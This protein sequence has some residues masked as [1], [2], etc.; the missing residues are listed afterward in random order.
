MTV[1]LPNEAPGLAEGLAEAPQLLCLLH[2]REDDAVGVGQAISGAGWIES[3]VHI[4]SVGVFLAGHYLGHASLGVQPAIFT[5]LTG[6]QPPPDAGVFLFSVIVPPMA[7]SMAVLEL[8]LVTADGPH[9]HQIRLQVAPDRAAATRARPRLHLISAQPEAPAALAPS[10]FLTCEE[11]DIADDGQFAVKGWAFCPDGETCVRVL[12]DDCEVAQIVPDGARPDVVRAHPGQPAAS[13]AGFRVTGHAAGP[14]AST[15]RLRLL[16]RGPDGQDYSAS[17]TLPVRPTSV[18]ALTFARAARPAIQCFLDLPKCS[19]NTALGVTRGD[20]VINGWAFSPHGVTEIAVLV[21]G[22]AVGNARRGIRRDDVQRAFPTDDPGRPGFSFIVPA[23]ALKA[24]NHAITI[25]IR[26][27]Q[28]NRETIAFQARTEPDRRATPPWPLRQ[29]LPKAEI[30]LAYALLAARDAQPC[31]AVIVPAEATDHAK[32]AATLASLRRQAY[33]NWRCVV[34]LPSG[35]DAAKLLRRLSDDLRG[36]AI[37]CIADGAALGALVPEADGLMVLAPGDRLAAD[38]LLEFAVAASG[39]AADFLYGDDRRLDPGDGRHK[40]FHKP[41][42]SPNLLI[43]T[44][45]IGRAWLARR[46]LVAG[47]GLTMGDMRDHGTWDAVLR[48]T[49]HAQQE[50]AG[51]AHF[52]HMLLDSQLT[53]VDAGQDRQAL[54]RAL[55]RRGRFGSIRRGPIAG[56]Y[57]V[58]AAQMPQP[59]RVS[60]II[61]TI[62]AGDLVRTAITSIRAYTAWPDYEIICIDNMPA[63]DDPEIV[64]RKAWLT[65]YADRVI[66]APPPFNWSRLNNLGAAAAT[67]ALLLFLNDDI[68]V[69]DTAWLGDLVAQASRP[70]I[71]LVGPQLLYPDGRVQH[72]GMFLAD[73][74]A[75][76][77]FRY[78]PAD[79]PGPFGLARTTREVSAITG[80]CMMMRRDVFDRLDGF[81]EAHA[82][83]NNDIDFCLRAQ[84][85][86]L[87]VLYAPDVSLVHHELAS[88]GALPDIYNIAQFAAA[89]GGRFALGDP[90]HPPALARDSDDYASDPEPVRWST[91]GRP[92]FDR[93]AVQRIL[94][95]KLDHIGDFI[96]A[97]PAFRRIK[98]HFPDAELVVLAAPGSQPLAALEPAIDRI[99]GF[100]FFHPRS[101]RGRRTHSRAVLDALGARLAAERFDLAIDLRRQSDTR[102]MLQASEATWFAGFDHDNAHPWL[103]ISVAFE[104]DE[105]R[106]FKRGHVSDSLVRLVDAVASESEDRRDL[107]L[108]GSDRVSA[109]ATLHALRLRTGMVPPE[110]SGPLVAIHAC[111]GSANKQWPLASFAALIDLLRGDGATILLVGAP[112][113]VPSIRRLKAL[114]RQPDQIIDLVGQTSMA[115]LA[116]LLPAV[117]LFVGNDSGPKHLAAGL[118][119]PTL[120]IHSGTVDAGEWGAV[121]AYALTIRKEVACSPCYLRRV[122]DCP[123]GMVCLTG[124]A[125]GDVYR[126]TQRLIGLVAS[127]HD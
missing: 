94:A 5:A 45:Y 63:D 108:T 119:V 90:L 122:A 106:Q 61:P 105:A 101:G 24:G 60:I 64:A 116:A 124:I 66:V 118:G 47:A 99:I 31:W 29:A 79:A 100:D 93:R 54:G 91:A 115:E 120:G 78:A 57:R 1:E 121:G 14:F 80:A 9:I 27:R 56:T 38:A 62:A 55:R 102:H 127:N 16:L 111:A 113:D 97:F 7:A 44:N 58:V 41:A 74:V 71:G 92:L 126:A 87:A 85:Q 20:L 2:P 95:V 51:V 3:S 70:E 53:P 49:E 77:A 96:T 76:H 42:F 86:G 73:K 30:D 23:L 18:P 72:A 103:D 84:A 125:V 22:I 13:R 17:R 46:A 35:A 107:I 40:G 69:T 4:A 88:R 89:W 117:D 28:G 65:A 67:G 104:G 48:L 52:P 123:R 43:A 19:D 26:D 110:R 34:A 33:R 68:E 36:V 83:V 15:A 8:R 32:V 37:R 81:D 21:D 6:A 11:A 39:Q 109:A 75:R 112:D 82:I 114:I 98:Q 25:V 10:A 12:I 59:P 50:G